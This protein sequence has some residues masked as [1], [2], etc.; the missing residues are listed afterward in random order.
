M[1]EEFVVTTECLQCNAFQTVCVQSNRAFWKQVLV[2]MTTACV[3]A[4][5]SEDLGGVWTDGVRGA[6]QLHQIQ[7]RRAQEVGLC[8]VRHAVRPRPYR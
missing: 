4:C 8:P 7:Q 6:G 1:Q 5:V 3:A 2:V